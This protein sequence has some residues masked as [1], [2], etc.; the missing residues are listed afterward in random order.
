MTPN[1]KFDEL[2]KLET[3]TVESKNKWKSF[4]LM[5]QGRIFDFVCKNRVERDQ[6][7]MQI[8]TRCTLNYHREIHWKTDEKDGN[9]KT[10]FLG[11]IGQR[12]IDKSDVSAYPSDP[13][14]DNHSVDD[15]MATNLED[16]DMASQEVASQHVTSQH[17]A[18][19]HVRLRHVQHVPVPSDNPPAIESF[20][21]SISALLKRETDKIRESQR[22]LLQRQKSI[23]KKY[24][25]RLQQKQREWDAERKS[26]K[27][28][29]KRL[30]ADL[31]SLHS[32]AA[33]MRIAD[34]SM[35][36]EHEEEVEQ[37]IEF[38]EQRSKVIS[39]LVDRMVSN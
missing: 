34:V 39:L 22:Q 23:E 12:D 28:E 37:E 3:N 8:L 11:G 18:G 36:I 38:K 16:D 1:I 35:E 2:A 19:Q 15:H 24:R 30:R 25:K 7:V 14:E 6:I 33:A 9:K 32:D 17:V 27:N 20:D 21:K 10:F 13:E 31:N 5:F 4:G 26:L 29:N